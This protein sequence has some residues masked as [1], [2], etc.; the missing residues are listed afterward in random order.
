MGWKF[1][2]EDG[3]INVDK[4]YFGKTV[5]EVDPNNLHTFRRKDSSHK[6]RDHGVHMH[7]CNQGEYEG[8]CK[9]GQDDKCPALKKPVEK[10]PALKKYPPKN[11]RNIT[12]PEIEKALAECHLQCEQS[13]HGKAALAWMRAQAKALD[14][15][16]PDDSGP[17][18]CSRVISSHI[19]VEKESKKSERIL[20]RVLKILKTMTPEKYAELYKETQKEYG[21]FF[22]ALDRANKRKK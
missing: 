16:I 12:D 3:W 2:N 11:P 13:E 1:E 4:Q 9:Y 18:T 5:A 8:S 14:P 10:C 22:K 19:V 17:L 20:E 21:P 7:H 15:R 6:A